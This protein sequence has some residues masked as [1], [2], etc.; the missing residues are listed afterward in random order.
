MVYFRFILRGVEDILEN[1]SK[2]M[3]LKA[4]VASEREEKNTTQGP[5]ECKLNDAFQS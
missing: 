1:G 4:I 3:N 5:V 2:I